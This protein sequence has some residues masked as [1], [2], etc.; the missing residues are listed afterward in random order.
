MTKYNKTHWREIISRENKIKPHI[1]KMWNW[2]FIAANNFSNNSFKKKKEINICGTRC[3]AFI[4]SELNSFFLNFL[5]GISLIRCCKLRF[6]FF[7]FFNSFGERELGKK[8]FAYLNLNKFTDFFFFFFTSSEHE[9]IPIGLNERKIYFLNCIFFCLPFNPAMKH[10][11]SQVYL[12]NTYESM[13]QF[14]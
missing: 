7:F 4:W 3:W 9:F 14:K 6:F 12:F 5:K 13:F 8:K 1:F 2:N 10:L 11:N